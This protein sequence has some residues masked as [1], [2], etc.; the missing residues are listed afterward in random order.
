MHG[1]QRMFGQKRISAITMESFFQLKPILLPLNLISKRTIQTHLIQP[2]PSSSIGVAGPVKLMV[3]DLLGR[4][5]VR[6]VDDYKSIG[7]YKAVWN[8]NSMPSGV[9]FYRI[10]AGDFVK[11]Q[12][13][14]LM[15]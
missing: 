2:P 10:E 8:A 12:K 11:T 15:K 9:Y 7:T 14:I 3:Y 1:K 5:M 6:L 4:E 13:M